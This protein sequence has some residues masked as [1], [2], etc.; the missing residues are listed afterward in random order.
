M[1]R[2]CENRNLDSYRRLWRGGTRPPPL[3]TRLAQ[4]AVLS[5]LRLKQGCSRSRPLGFYSDKEQSQR[6]PP[7]LGLLP[8]YR[9]LRSLCGPD[10]LTGFRAQGSRVIPSAGGIPQCRWDGARLHSWYRLVGITGIREG[11]N[12]GSH[13]ETSR[14]SRPRFQIKRASTTGTRTTANPSLQSRAT[15]LRKRNRDTE[16]EGPV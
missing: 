1:S 15:S 3:S 14:V 8:D 5:R 7:P 4:V 13:R 12:P 11:R 9:E 2:S 16:R 6:Y 10:V